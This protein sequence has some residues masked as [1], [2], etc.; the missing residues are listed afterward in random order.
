MR[1]AASLIL[2]SHDP[3]IEVGGSRFDIDADRP[4]T[5]GRSPECEIF[6]R[7]ENNAAFG[8]ACAGGWGGRKNLSISFDADGWTL[9]HL[10][11]S[12][13]IY[14]NHRPIRSTV[15]LAPGD[16]IEPAVDV[17]VFRFE[18]VHSAADVAAYRLI[19][20][21]LGGVVP[22]RALM[23]LGTVDDAYAYV[24]VWL[25]LDRRFSLTE[26][27]SWG[28]PEEAAVEADRRLELG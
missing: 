8:R 3:D 11:H 17:L 22:L 2:E 1:P 5:L 13:I 12:G 20:S 28:A 6:V 15:R 14:V 25:R 23:E 24:D 16:R 19:Q 10:G 4:M 26:I 9:H 27:G 7:F 21:S 18:S